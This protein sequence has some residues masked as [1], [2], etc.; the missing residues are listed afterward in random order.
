MI[1]KIISVSMQQSEL[2]VT[3]CIY[4]IDKELISI[5]YK[6]LKQTIKK[7]KKKRKWMKYLKMCLSK[8]DT[9]IDNNTWKRFS[10]A[11]DIKGIQS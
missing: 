2:K 8:E 4:E 6:E 10:I 1:V 7:K 5:I 11:L 9:N 3:I